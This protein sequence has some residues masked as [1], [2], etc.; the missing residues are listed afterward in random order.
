V[1]L[2][3]DEQR[4]LHEIERRFYE[5]DPKY[6]ES[7]STATLYRALWKKCRR[8]IIGFCVGLVVLLASFASSWVVGAIGFFIMLVCAVIFTRNLRK[9]GH[10]GWQEVSQQM[11]SRNLEGRVADASEKLRDRFKRER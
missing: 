9:L 5:H 2:S 6:A 1:P 7:I 4:A 11:R 8:A 10:A 3:E